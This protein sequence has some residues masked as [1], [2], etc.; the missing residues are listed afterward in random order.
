MTGCHVDL[1]V[2]YEF[3]ELYETKTE[4]VNLAGHTVDKTSRNNLNMY[5]ENELFS[6]QFMTEREKRIYHKIKKRK[7]GAKLVEQK[8]KRSL[9]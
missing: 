8:V 3:Q 1:V 2:Q 9:L 4:V 7:R 5:L 6:D